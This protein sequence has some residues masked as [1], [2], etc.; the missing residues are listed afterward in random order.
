MSAIPLPICP[1]CRQTDQVEKVKSIYE[2]NTKEWYETRTHTGM[3][4]QIESY[5]EFHEAHTLLGLKLKPPDGPSGPSHPGIWYGIGGLAVFILL[6]VLC[7]LAVGLLSLLVP[8]FI[9][10]TL[11]PNVSDLPNWEVLAIIVGSGALCLGII[12]IIFIIWLGFR[13]KNRFMRDME[14]YK[15]KKE[16]YEREEIPPWER[17]KNRWEKL[18]YCMRD[19][20]V[21]IPEENKAIQAKDMEKYLYNPYFQS[22]K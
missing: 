4:G 21:F 19:E 12:G 15:E 18:Y 16:T 17:A 3:H 9:G 11:I 20:T 1:T 6:S 7:P 8:I 10:A 2:A 5:K 13:I 22:G 14:N